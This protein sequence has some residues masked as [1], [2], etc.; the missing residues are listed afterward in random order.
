MGTAIK[1]PGLAQVLCQTGL[2]RHL[3]FLTPGHSDA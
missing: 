3:E 1:H 2:S